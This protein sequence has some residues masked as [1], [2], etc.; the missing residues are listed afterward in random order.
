MDNVINCPQCGRLFVKYLREHCD[1]C[2]KEEEQQYDKVYRFIRKSENR[3]ATIIDVSEATSVSENKIIYFIHQGR[4][5]VKGFPNF[6]YPCDG[7]Q[8]PIND[9]RLCQDC[10]TR[11]MAD[12]SIE[13]LIKKKQQEVLPSYHTEDK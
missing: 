12:L 2:F 9:S 11:I 4:I 10:K 3:N 5:R 6:T 7:C 8:K 1:V 13:D